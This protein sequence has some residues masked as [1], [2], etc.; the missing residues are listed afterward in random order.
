MHLVGLRRQHV[1]GDHAGLFEVAVGEGSLGIFPGD[2]VVLD[3]LRKACPPQQGWM[4]CREEDAS[5]SFLAG[6]GGSNESWLVGDD[7]GQVSGPLSQVPH[8]FF[9]LCEVASD[10]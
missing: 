4:V 8:E 6:V 9:E 3:V 10:V 7:F 2:H 1:L 5:H